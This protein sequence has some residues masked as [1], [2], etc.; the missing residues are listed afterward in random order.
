MKTIA[1]LSSEV[2]LPGSPIR[3]EDAFEHD[4][5]MDMLRPAHKVLGYDLQDI[6][7]DDPNADWSRYSAAIIGTT[8]DYWDHQERFLKTL[9]IIAN[10]TPLFNS[11]DMVSW[12]SHKSY[13]KEFS[14][15]GIATIP[16]IWLDNPTPEAT[17]RA[18]DE[19]GS[20]D[21]VFKRQVGAGAEGQHRLIRSDKTP[22]FEHAM[23]AQPFLPQI[24]TEGEFSFIF[25]DGEFC[26]ALLKTAK[27][28]DYRIQSSYGGAEDVYNPTT[29]EIAIAKNIVAQMDETPLYARVDMIRG[30]DGFLLMELELIEPYLYPK[31]GPELGERLAAATVARLK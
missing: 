23:M 31:E 27:P 5:M 12:N 6:A 9:G 22:T 15:N 11:P 18:F 2:T 28:G 26:H 10:K 13:L 21:L 8:W 1:Y 17:A 4:Y 7:W 30:E 25:V 16:T 14:A 20:D 3:R 29:D 19:L 24:Q